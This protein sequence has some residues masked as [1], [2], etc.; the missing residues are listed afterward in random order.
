MAHASW[1]INLQESLY[2]SK[3]VQFDTSHKAPYYIRRLNKSVVL[4]CA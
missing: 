3:K 2:F 1:R 4:T